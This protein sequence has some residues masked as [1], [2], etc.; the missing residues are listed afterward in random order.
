M[1]ASKSAAAPF[2]LGFLDIPQPPPQPRATGWTIMTDHS[3]PLA[4]QPSFLETVA[5]ILDRV[6][7]FEGMR[8]G[9]HRAIGYT[10][11]TGAGKA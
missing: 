7:A 5:G 4:L 1:T 6:I 10:F 8:R 11:F 9:L 2:A 3:M